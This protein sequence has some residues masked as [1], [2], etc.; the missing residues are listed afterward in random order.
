MMAK[1]KDAGAGQ[2]V[3]L[4]RLVAALGDFEPRVLGPSGVAVS[5]VTEDSRKVEPGDLFV[6]RRGHQ[7]DG[8]R[9]IEQAIARGARAV[10]LGTEATLRPFGV[11]IL[12]V[13]DLE[14]ALPRA[15]AEVYGHP[16]QSIDVVGITGTNGKTTTAWMVGHVLNQIGCRAGRLGTLG[17]SWADREERGSLTTPQAEAVVRYAA[18]V[19][20]GGGTHFVLEVSSHALSQHRVDGLEFRVAALTNLTQDHLDYHL[21]LR[22]YRAAKRRLFE[23]FAVGTSV[24]NAD[25]AFGQE[26]V[27]SVVSPVLTFGRANL[28]ADIRPLDPVLMEGRVRTR[29]KAPSGECFLDVPVLGAHNL[30][31][32]LC[33]LAIVEALGLDLGKAGAALCRLPQIPGRLE[34]CDSETD[35][36]RVVV[37]YAHTPDALS[38][39]L[40][41]VRPLTSGSVIC[42]FGCGGDRDRD[43]RP[44]M[45]ASVSAGADRAI[46]TNDNPRSEQP[47]AIVDAIV[48]SLES[49]RIPFEVVLDRHAAIEQAIVTAQ[50][51]DVVMIAGKG[52]ED[53]QILGA[54]R[55][56]FDDREQARAALV[57]RRAQ[58][59]GAKPAGPGAKPTGPS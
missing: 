24:L 11:A 45:G 33:C 13:S 10:M 38:R 12:R 42:V 35:D 39:A 20:D 47:E 7:F 26:L 14:R 22:E 21:S 58:L 34:R 9:F 31:N 1:L 53:Y 28:A 23:D 54:Q 17:F 27:K 3:P 57:L 2:P 6:A 51:G 25:D 36:I 55:V 8:A 52:H 4:L 37:D 19:R 44:K 59:S 43:K 50:P 48:P 40:S 5:G 46:V 41:A 30:D 56:F 15:A 18:R 49:A 16:S 29:V 32:I